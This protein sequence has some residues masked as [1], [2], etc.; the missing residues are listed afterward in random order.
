M[1]RS[2]LNYGRKG[3]PIQ[4]ISAVDLALWDVLGKLR[5]EPVYNL[6]GGRTK[7]RLPVYAT[8]SRP[9]LAQKMGFVGAKFPLPYGPVEGDVGM[10]KNIE[11]I[12]LVRNSVGPDFP[13]M[14]DCYMALTTSY[15][16]E[17]CR[18]IDREV[19]NGVKWVEEFL[20]PDD[21]AGYKE[22]KKKV[23]TT[24]LTCGEH[25]Y[26]RYGFRMLLE[27]N[28]VDVLQPDITWVGGLTE[29][30]KIVSM[31]SAYDIPVIPHGSSV[32]S[33]HLQYAFTNCPMAE[34]LVLSPKADKVTPLFGQLFLDEPLPHDGYVVLDSKKFGFGFTLNPEIRLMGPHPHK[35][36]GDLSEV[37]QHGWLEKAFEIL[38]G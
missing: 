25:E 8:T 38:F 19:E 36:W 32:Y 27:N 7:Q 15:T 29:A 1:Y 24:L 11:R 3:L 34:F 35:K 30:K 26:T 28:C 2:T 18:R 12:K 31:A 23:T 16:I 13:I 21:Y 10:K 20:P 33:Y 37:V 9:D 14:I 4:A 22:V 5:K 6:L 17:L